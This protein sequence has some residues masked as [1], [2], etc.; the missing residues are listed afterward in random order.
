MARAAAVYC[1]ISKDDQGDA[2]G[3]KRQRDDAAAYCA[4]HGYEAPVFYEDNDYSASSYAVKNRPEFDRMIESARAGELDVIVLYDLDRLT[5]VPRVGEDI[6]D[7]AA[8]GLTIIDG[9]GTHDLTTGDGRHRFR[10]A[11][12]NAALESDKLSK[13]MKRKKAEL[14]ERG[15]PAGGGRAFCYEPD[16][17]TVRESEAVAYRQAA[18]DVLAG[19]STTAIAK[20]WNA[21]GLRTARSGGLWAQVMVRRVLTSPRH[22]GLRAHQ[23]EVIGPAVWPAIVDRAT[24]EALVAVLANGAKK[25]PR[26]R[27]LLTGLVRCECGAPMSRDGRSWRCRPSYRHPEACGRVQV[28]AVPL[29]ALVEEMIVEL[30]GSPKLAKAM[31]NEVPVHDDAALDL[32]KAEATM[33]ELA[34]MFSA[35]EITR[36]EWLRAR[37]GVE[38]R[39]ADARRRLARR[40]GT[41]AL[42]RFRGA[43]APALYGKMEDVDER[44]AVIGALLD[45]VVI[46]PAKNRAPRLDVDRVDPIWR[47]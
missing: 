2:L 16:G 5:R 34:D 4:E 40:T 24:F 25:N 21:Q 28:R 13:R 31:A 19:K 39:L 11:I 20:E 22:A 35:G 1:R 6:I 37:K 10:G 7:L 14:A 3:V 36:A 29:E 15:V 47:V 9:T 27:S 46:H 42:E 23:G 26:R 45:H 43:D 12:S 17:V 30:L 18:R 8:K 33:T 38:E 44:R 32:S 41:D